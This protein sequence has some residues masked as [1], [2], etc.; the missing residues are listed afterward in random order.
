MEPSAHE[1][2]QLLRDQSEAD[3]EALGKLTPVVY[4]ELHR[5]ALRCMAQECPGYTL[6]TTV[7]VNDVH[8]RLG[9]IRERTWQDRAFFQEETGERGNGR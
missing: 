8:L 5:A 3:Q 7:L 1:V 9:N 2:T 6:Q 4:E